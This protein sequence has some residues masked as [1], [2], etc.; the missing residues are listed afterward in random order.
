[1][2]RNIIMELDILNMFVD[3]DMY[4]RYS[5]FINKSS[6]SKETWTILED[7]GVWYQAG[8][9]AIY[10]EPFRTWFFLV[11]HTLMKEDQCIIFRKIFERAEILKDK[12]IDPKIIDSF[13]QRD[14][15]DKITEVSSVIAEGGLHKSLSDIEDLLS[16][17]NKEIDKAGDLDMMFVTTDLD[18]LFDSIKHKKTIRWRLNELNGAC[19]PIGKGDLIVV[20]ARPDAGKTTFLASEATFMAQQLEPDQSVLWFNNEEEGTKVFSRIIGSALATSVD[21]VEANRGLYFPQYKRMMGG[22]VDKIKVLDRAIIHKSDI[23]TIVKNYNVGL[24]VIDQLWKVA[25]FEKESTTEVDRQTKLFAWAREMAKKTCPV[26]TVNQADGSAEGQLY[27]EMNQ[28]YGSKTG[29]QGE[30][31]AIITLGK[32]FSSGYENVRGLYVPK[33]KLKGEDPSCRNGKFEVLL[34]GD[35]ARFEGV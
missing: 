16:A 7:M 8:G 5:R 14:Y 30:A 11:R 18:E 3:K 34:R 26:I 23:E 15:A 24:I 4:D 35:I 32:S 20:G 29:V 9:E 10:W 25:G 28:L 17:Y 6:V 33:N 12:A 21:M 19:G 31:D 13:I 22:R 1:M 27:I 2:S